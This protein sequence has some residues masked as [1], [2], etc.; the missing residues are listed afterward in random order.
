MDNI[1][2]QKISD[3]EHQLIAKKLEEKIK[4]YFCTICTEKNWNLEPF[5]VPL[6]LSND[7]SVRLGGQVLP[8]VAITCANCGNTH[9]FN[10]VTLG[11]LDKI[12]T[13]EGNK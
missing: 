6:S 11:L 1:N 10:L 12:K 9:F 8:L 3:E 4:N 5:I 7:I 13:K 2:K